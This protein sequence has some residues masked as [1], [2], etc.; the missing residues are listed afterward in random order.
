MKEPRNPDT[1]HPPLAAYS[2]QIEI[3]GRERMLVI[4]GQ[5][6]VTPDGSI[7]EDPIEQLGVVLDNIERNLEA[8]GMG[9][10]DLVKLTVYLV[11]EWDTDAR[12]GLIASRLGMH[13]PTTTAVFVAALA[14]PSLRVEIEAWAS[15]AVVS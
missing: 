5:V 9:L 15:R 12:R 14:A 7:P 4:S 3:S 6:G 1:V 13:R 11:G 8:A 2:H 10:G